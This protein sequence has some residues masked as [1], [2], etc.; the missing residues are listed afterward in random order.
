M[1]CLTYLKFRCNGSLCCCMQTNLA[2]VATSARGLQ[3]QLDLL[4]VYADTWGL[5]VNIDKTKAVNFQQSPSNQ[6]YPTTMYDSAP[7]EIVNSFKYLGIVLH[8]TKSFASAAV[9][10]SEAGERSQIAMFCRCSEQGVKDPALRMQLWDSP[11]QPCILYGV[12]FWGATDICKGVL[13]GDGL[14]RD[15][16]QRLLGVHSGT[17][18]M[19]VLMED[20]RYPLEVKAAKL[21]VNSGPGWSRWMMVGWSSRLSCTALHWGRSP[22]RTPLTSHGLAKWARSCQLS[23][24][25]AISALHR[26]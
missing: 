12:E 17:P 24:C 6:V 3:S 2:P 26:Q 23:A 22:A 9:S 13:A 7:I 10:L 8:C 14:H 20:G 15:F 16:L 4:H 18:N 25:H 19:A 5:T 11:I 21:L 1:K